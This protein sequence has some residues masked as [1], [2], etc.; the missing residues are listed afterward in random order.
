MKLF[1]PG[2]IVRGFFRGEWVADKSGFQ[3]RV[4]KAVGLEGKNALH[5][6]EV[7]GHCFDPTFSPGPD[8]GADVLDDAPFKSV[9]SKG[10]GHKHV[11]FC[12]VD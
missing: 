8:S 3:R 6:V 5:L 2:G 9:F 7:F 11:E 10:F 12:V 4:F 1:T